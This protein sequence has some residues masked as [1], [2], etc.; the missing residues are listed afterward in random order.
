MTIK[1][2][3]I[4]YLKGKGWV[5]KNVL[6]KGIGQKDVSNLSRNIKSSPGTF[7][8]KKEGKRNMIRLT[9]AG[10]KEK[11]VKVKVTTPAPAEVGVPEHIAERLPKKV[12]THHTHQ[13]KDYMKQ[14]NVSEAIAKEELALLKM[15]KTDKPLELGK[16]TPKKHLDVQELERKRKHG[17]E[18][19]EKAITPKEAGAEVKELIKKKV[20]K[21]K[22]VIEVHPEVEKKVIAGVSIQQLRKVK[23]GKSQLKDLINELVLNLPV[24]KVDYSQYGMK[25]PQEYRTY[26]LSMID[27]LRKSD[28]SWIKRNIRVKGRQIEM[29]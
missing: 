26:L 14:H 8:T 27:L 6:A 17:A 18:E 21:P 5:E 28:G 3:M 22:K 4:E 7:E 24:R 15:G 9:K 19:P 1:D 16:I 25:T 11:I 10:K 2:K 12:P 29:D 20:E 23:R 13:V